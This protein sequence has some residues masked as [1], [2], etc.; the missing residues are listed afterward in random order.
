MHTS[1]PDLS[2]TTVH[3]DIFDLFSS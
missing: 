1:A 2:V 3:P